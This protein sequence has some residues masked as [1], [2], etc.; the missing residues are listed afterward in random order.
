MSFIGLSPG[1][2]CRQKRLMHQTSIVITTISLLSLNLIL[3][4]M[5]CYTSIYSK[6]F[7][8]LSAFRE[9]IMKNEVFIIY[10]CVALPNIKHFNQVSDNWSACWRCSHLFSSF[11][12]VRFKE[13]KPLF[14]RR[15]DTAAEED[16]VAKQ[17]FETE[18]N[19]KNKFGYLQSNTQILQ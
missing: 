18:Q 9:C 3:S 15:N 13:Y 10:L 7:W 6:A 2:H 4:C 17:Y 5:R 1:G 12:R 11:L 14:S 16:D 8:F 19:F